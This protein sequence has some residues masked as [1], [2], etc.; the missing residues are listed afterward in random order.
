M[1]NETTNTEKQRLTD[2][3]IST[4]NLECAK[5]MLVKA[6]KKQ[7]RSERLHNLECCLTLHALI[8]YIR[9]LEIELGVDAV[10]MTS[11]IPS[12]AVHQITVRAGQDIR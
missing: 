1:N 4:K 10:H 12:L 8:T 6:Y 7:T 11:S 3:A 9:H 2:S 5:K